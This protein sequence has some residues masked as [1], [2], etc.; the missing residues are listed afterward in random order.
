MNLYTLC[1]EAEIAVPQDVSDVEIN[2]ICTDSRTVKNGDMFICIRGMTVDGHAYME[3]AIA[4][5]ASVI[6]AEDLRPLPKDT[7]ILCVEDTRHAA[8]MLYD[9][10]YGH[11]SHKLKLIAVTGTNGKT[12]VTYMLLRIFEAAMCRC[13]VIG[14]VHSYSAGRMLDIRSDNPLANMTTPDPEE[15][16]RILS[17]MARDGV[18]YVFMEATS[19]A[20]ALR[21][22][23]ALTFDAAIF[24]NLTPEHLDFHENMENYFSTK[25]RLFSMC[26]RAII[27]VDDAYGKRLAEEI[28]CPA[29]TC[30]AREETADF[31]AEQI[32]DLGADGNEYDLVSRNLRVTL[33]TPIPGRFTVMNTLEAAAC[34][35]SF[36]VA[37]SAIM[38]AL[39]SLSGVDGRMERIKLGAL[40]DFSVF[41]DYAHTPD[42][43]YNLLITAR[44]F[45]RTGQRIVLVFGCGG[46]RDKAK[47]PIMGKL[48]S[49]LSDYCIITSDNS[50]NE[51]PLQIIEEIRG[52]MSATAY[53]VIPDRAEAI[54]HA[55]RT[56]LRGDIILLAGKGHEEYEIDCRGKRPFSER[57][58][59][60]AAATR[61]YGKG[62]ESL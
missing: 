43:L 42:A 13:G 2:G 47:R 50:R 46:D 39:G 38:A 60:M 23:D 9:A 8:A 14:T 28:D 15:L 24:T 34:A 45:R 33:R 51:D 25:A 55:I 7:P 20:I 37:P 31:L 40:C 6:V 53:A 48:A 58:I 3:E 29:L 26:K 36:G 21:K 5:G 59:A 19:H 32:R 62:E 22:L 54:D 18:E 12:S 30:S 35:S 61:Y 44:G 17:V 57:A 10:W 41:I 56:A 49:E 52:G 11:P 1:R 4:R 16:Y 27:N